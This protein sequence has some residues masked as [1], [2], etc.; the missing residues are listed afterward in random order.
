MA[1]ALAILPAGAALAHNVSVSRGTFEVKADGARAE[2]IIPMD[3]LLHAFRPEPDAQ[4][5]YAA[6]VLDDCVARYGARIVTHF[7]V[8][9]EAGER[10][11]GKLASAS[12]DLPAAEHHTVDAARRARATFVI[13][14]DLPGPPRL[15]TLQ[16]TFFQEGPSH[17]AQL[18]LEVRVADDAESLLVPLTNYGNVATL[19]FKAPASPEASAARRV[20]APDRFKAL[21]GALTISDDGAT[22]EL[23]LPLALVE[24]WATV[25]RADRDFLAPGEQPGACAILRDLL[26]RH[27]VLSID[28]ETVP[29]EIRAVRVLGPVDTVSKDAAPPARLSAH[30]ARVAAI[31][32]YPAASMPKQVV[33]RWELLNNAVLEAEIVVTAAGARRVH[34]LTAY[35]PELRWLRSTP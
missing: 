2:L 21:L 10:L 5:R 3:D 14:Y 12:H 29:A 24:T 28:G 15:L 31:L 4:E 11:G 22:L 6:T 20:A 33:L 30:T 25:P 26:A 1:A 17:A 16:Q 34:H 27:N 8:R 23:T 35:A 18:A 13:D 9:D 32:R 19:E 7:I